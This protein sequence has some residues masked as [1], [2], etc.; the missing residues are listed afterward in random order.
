MNPDNSNP[1]AGSSTDPG[2]S[3]SV[4]EIAPPS[5][6]TQP[7][8]PSTTTV[9]PTLQPVVTPQP[10][11]TPQPVATPQP[12]ITPQPVT[13]PTDVIQPAPQPSTPQDMTNGQM[14]TN[15]IT[16]TNNASTIPGLGQT[17]PN[18][19]A[20]GPIINGQP[21]PTISGTGPNLNGFNANTHKHSVKK[22]LIIPAVMI[23]VLLLGIGGYVFGLYLP[24]KPN[25]VWSTGLKRTGKQLDAIVEK[26]SDPEAM[27][28]LTKNKLAIS[29]KYTSDGGTISGNLESKYD[30]TNT[31]ST[32]KLEASSS[33]LDQDIDITIDLKTQIVENAIW[34][35]TY[36]RLN[37]FD[38]FGLESY[39]VDTQLFNNK[40]ISIEQDD[41]KDLLGQTLNSD[42]QAEENITQDEIMTLVADISSVNNEY[43]FTDDT[44]KAVIVADKFVGTEES[45]GITANRY[46]ASIN[47]ANTV[48][49]CKA[50][51]E[52]LYSNATYTKFVFDESDDIDK[53]KEK[54][55]ESCETNNDESTDTN[56]NQ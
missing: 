46:E 41:Y 42:E 10:I 13:T 1:P 7:I 8:T 24:N 52:K 5:P 44:S 37:G 22:T 49:Y 35:N 27:K 21:A 17:Q 51:T 55:Q 23:A 34:P 33:Y 53:A 39:G 6:E 40:W 38:S 12:V 25:N 29:G 54:D 26:L 15:I 31:D 45:E 19:P 18:T 48:L 43:I 2:A 56:S 11:T 30:K 9:P 32:L 36:F 14:S 50:L 28:T 16:P 3:S 4:P 20:Q 47:Q